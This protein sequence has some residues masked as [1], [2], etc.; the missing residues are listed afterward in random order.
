M[1]ILSGKWGGRKI[2]FVENAATHPMGEREKNAMFNMVGEVSGFLV[3]DWCAGSG[4]I[5]LECI[6]RGAKKVVFVEKERK[7]IESIREN[8]TIFEGEGSLSR[9]ERN[10]EALKLGE[11]FDLI[12]FDPPYDKFFNFNFLNIE[13]MLNGGGKFVLSSPKKAEIPEISGLKMLKSKTYAGARITI[14]Q[15]L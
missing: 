14:Y 6:S 1:R 11:K 12:F 13:K 7:N 15:K 2:I 4:Q 9:V 5:G 3:L 10:L 8:L